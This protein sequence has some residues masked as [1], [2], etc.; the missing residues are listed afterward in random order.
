[1]KLIRN[2]WLPTVGLGTKLTRNVEIGLWAALLA[3]IALPT[4]AI[5]AGPGNPGHSSPSHLL[6]HLQVRLQL[7]M[8]CGFG[9]RG[10]TKKATL[11]VGRVCLHSIVGILFVNNHGGLK[12]RPA[13]AVN[14]AHARGSTFYSGPAAT[15]PISRMWACAAV[16]HNCRRPFA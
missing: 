16:N 11:K 10:T 15:P 12:S 14:S 13:S 2:A 7:M 9:R 1:M 3:V 4:L 8:V 6:L 5:A